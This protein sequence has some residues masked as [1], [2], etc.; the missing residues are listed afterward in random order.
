M[1]KSVT[2]MGQLLIRGNHSASEDIKTK[3]SN[4]E[5]KMHTLKEYAE[6][7]RH[8]LEEAFHAHQVSLTCDL[9]L[10]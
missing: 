9:I 1:F 7:R 4:L 2:E 3:L 6:A 5:A 8:R 10:W